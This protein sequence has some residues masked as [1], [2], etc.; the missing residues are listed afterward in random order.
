[1]CFHLPADF[2]ATSGMVSEERSVNYVMTQIFFGRE[3]EKH[4]KVYMCECHG[5]V[6][7]CVGLCVYVWVCEW[8][9]LCMSKKI[10]ARSKDSK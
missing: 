6:C 7:V 9:C 4:P 10:T 5:C 3:R 8:V 1:M 2:V